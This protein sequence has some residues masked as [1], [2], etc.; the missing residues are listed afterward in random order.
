MLWA[1][2]ARLQRRSAASQVLKF[3]VA[4][5]EHTSYPGMAALSPDGRYLTFSAV[6]PEGRRML[7]LRPLDANH[8]TPIA[9]TEG[10]F[11]PFWSPG[12]REIGFFADRAMKRVSLDGGAPVTLSSTENLTGGGTWNADG[13]IV[14]ASGVSDGLFKVPASGGTPQPLTRLNA[15]RRDRAHLWPYFLPGGKHFLFFVQAGSQESTGIYVGSLDGS[16]PQ[17][18]ITAQTNAVYSNGGS[19]GY[20]VFGHGRDLVAQEFDVSSR[21]V[22]GPPVVLAVG[23]GAVESMMLAPVS[24]SANGIMAYQTLGKPT[25]QLVWFDRAGRQTGVLGGPGEYGPPR[26]SPDGKK[27]AAGKLPPG[28]DAADVWVLD[29]DTGS[30]SQVTATPDTHEGSPVWSPD[31]ER[32]AYFWNVSGVFDLF[33]KPAAR[34]TEPVLLVHTGT[35]KYPNDWSHDGRFLLFTAVDAN[36]ANDIWVVPLA[37]DRKPAPV[38]QTIYNES[39]GVFSPDQ[40]WLAYQ[41]DQGGQVECFVQSFP[42][43]DPGIPK[44]WPVSPGGGGLPKWRRDGQEIFYITSSGKL[45]SAAVREVGSE[46]QADPPRMLFQTRPLPRSWNTFD[47]APDGEHFLLNLPLEWSSAA[48]ITV[49]TNWTDRLR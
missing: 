36:T 13:V 17:K 11:A 18:V 38:V 44:R 30:A 45:M 2:I 19:K 25:H 48:P 32:L 16:E 3:D 5:P 27:V 43:T 14:F 47:V 37:G 12:G 4:P 39:F 7:W 40:K 46:F 1:G 41:S 24:S 28:K 33:A 49:I 6:G 21:S 10:A 8:A 26:I 20:L 15:G 29:V 22:S 42:A 31:G 34:G 9:G 35:A 23:V